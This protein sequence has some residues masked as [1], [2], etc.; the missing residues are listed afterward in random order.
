MPERPEQPRHKSLA[1]DAHTFPVAKAAAPWNGTS[2]LMKSTAECYPCLGRLV[3]Q[4]AEIATQDPDLRTRVT[5]EGMKILSTLFS[6]E[7]TSISVAMPIHHMVKALTG[8][9]DPYA[10]MKAAE[11]AMARQLGILRGSHHREDLRSDIMLAVRGNTIDFF[12]NAD[13]IGKELMLPVDFA[14][15]DTAKL[16]AR[17]QATERILYLADN[18]GEVLFDL[19]L[20]DTLGNHGIVTYAVKA[21]PIQNDVTLSDLERYDLLG[22]LP[23]VITTGTDTPGVYLDQA[24]TEFRSEFEAADL[25]VAKGMGYWETFSES[26]PTDKVVHLL[27]AKCVPVAN[28]LGVKLDS[29]VALLR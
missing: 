1:P 11:I 19:R 23:R 6:L 22:H 5:A 15:D 27:K 25:V 16:E 12:K 7:R 3:S 28:S 13:E 29:Y 9:P 8:N 10:Q 17:L 4:A 24:S 20:V 18:M 14:I 21:A 26:P 2:L